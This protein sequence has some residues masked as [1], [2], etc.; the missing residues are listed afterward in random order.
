MGRA[1]QKLRYS[2]KG[3]RL[4]GPR[5]VGFFRTHFW[6]H[7]A[8]ET[9]GQS[10]S[11][12]NVV[13]IELAVGRYVIEMEL[14]HNQVNAASVAK[15]CRRLIKA[16]EEFQ[17]A[18][19]K[20]LADPDAGRHVRYVITSPPPKEFRDPPI[21]L[22][23][24]WWSR[25][26]RAK[27]RISHELLRCSDPEHVSENPWD[28][29][30]RRVASILRDEGMRPT[31]FSYASRNHRREPTPFV[32]FIVQ[33]QAEMPEWLAQ[34]EPERAGH[35]WFSISKAVQRALRSAHFA[36]H[37]PRDRSVA[38]G[39]RHAGAGPVP[40]ARRKPV[41][42]CGPRAGAAAG[43]VCRPFAARSLI[44]NESTGQPRFGAPKLGRLSCCRVDWHRFS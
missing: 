36:G 43:H 19:E 29:W 32:R 12:K 2:H 3:Q 15:T 10:L 37:D 41:C 1:P 5:H 18:Y 11:P 33:M 4:P 23:D 13:Q 17:R 24:E 34:H 42:R 31:A 40:V 39:D 7:E 21:W 14:I 16:I 44:Q 38:H 26:D 25:L 35:P 6:T 9:L 28:E 27:D 20:I 8:P 30:V 22:D